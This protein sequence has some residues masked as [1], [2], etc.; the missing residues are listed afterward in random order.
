MRKT[1]AIAAK[2]HY[3]MDEYEARYYDISSLY[4]LG[5]ELLSAVEAR[6][7]AN[8]KA[9]M[10]L[11]E[12]LIN[13]LADA[14]DLLGEEF[15]F[16]AESKQKRTPSKASKSQIEGALRK[17]CFAINDYKARSK[18]LAGRIGAAAIAITDA[19]VAK[20]Q[21]QIDTV[22]GI[23]FEFIQV[24]LQQI[25]SKTELEALRLRDTRIAMLMHQMSLAQQ[26]HG[27]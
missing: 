22:V 15:L 5:E 18:Q 17:L 1:M 13:D 16:I 11:V 10:D 14:A 21:K 24:S 23:F 27:G 8:P 25:M 3:S 4:L 7:S 12:P 9:H 20:V 2:K 19:I 26:Q 6:S